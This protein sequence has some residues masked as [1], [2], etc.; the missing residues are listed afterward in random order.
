MP[1]VSANVDADLAPGQAAGVTVLEGDPRAR[2]RSIF[3]RREDGRVLS[4]AIFACEP[5]RTAFE[6]E[7]DEI[8]QVLEGEVEISLDDGSRVELGPGD[9]AVL[10][11]GHRSEWWIK[12]PF[13][14]LAILT[15]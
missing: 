1:I 13:K 9:V 4:V 2:R 12:T 14:E 3:E 15:S 8:V 5:A 11:K 10:P 6:L 7:H